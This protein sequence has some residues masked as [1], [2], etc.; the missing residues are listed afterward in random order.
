MV[1]P[2]SVDAAFFDSLA[3]VDQDNVVLRVMAF[4]GTVEEGHSQRKETRCVVLR[5]FRQA[6]ASFMFD[7]DKGLHANLPARG[8]RCVGM[9][10]VTENE[11]E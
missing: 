4:G 6:I 10:D 3:I 8:G 11:L 9:V 5:W 1:L 2:E 7:R